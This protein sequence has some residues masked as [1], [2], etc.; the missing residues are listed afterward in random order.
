MGR[1]INPFTDWGFKHIFG[2][3]V[4][5][6]ILIEFLNDLLQGERVIKDLRFLNNEGQPEQKELRK[7]IYDIYC[8]TD[9]GEY[10]IVEMQNRRQ[11]HFKER[12]LFYQSQAIYRQ[13]TK[14]QNWDFRL[15]AV[16]GVYFANFYLDGKDNGKLRRD[17]VLADTETH[18][19]FCDKLRQIYIELPY[20]IK[21][22]EECET[23]FERW[24]YVLKYMEVLE[25]MPF[26]GRKAVFDRL[27]QM[28]SKANMTVAERQQYEEE[29]KNWND[30]Y[31]T[32]D[33]A[34]K[35]GLEAGYAEGLQIGMEK[36]IAEGM[37]KGIAE[38]LEKGMAEGLEKGMA[39]GLERGMAEGI[40]LTARNLKQ[41]GIS[42]EIIAQ[43]TG[44]STEEIDQL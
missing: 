28:A 5:K 44:L 22:E 42:K 13:G 4:S 25:R 9:T 14:G 16:Y 18:E 30:Y 11:E 1:F 41:A 12:A 34:K 26:K 35:E 20:F 24:I 8:E 23:D 21:K 27:E 2:R 6:D 19:V 36:G 38:G 40:I 15:D 33:Y 17:I 37:E 43:T 39:E 31:N 7:V 10:I 32:L 3:E 29:W